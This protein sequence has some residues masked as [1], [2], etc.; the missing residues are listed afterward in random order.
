M[1]SES[2]GTSNDLPRHLAGWLPSRRTNVAPTAPITADWRGGPRRC[3][4]CDA[5]GSPQLVALNGTTPDFSLSAGSTATATVSPG[6]TATYTISVAPSGGFNQSVMFTCTGAPALTTCAVSPNP[7]SQNGTSA[8]MATVTVTTTAPSHGFAPPFE[9]DARWKVN[10]GPRLF[11]LGVLGMLIIASLLVWHRNRRTRWAPL[12]T[13]TVLLCMGITI[14][15]CGG[16]SSPSSTG[17]P[18]TQAGTYTITVSGS[19]ALSSSTSTHT[20]TL[21]LVVQ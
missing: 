8:A 20:A 11:M 13:L 2:L 18:G 21:T 6:Q 16:G 9:F 19:P 17:S 7:L 3:R 1:E 10:H 5:T 12:V 15:S 4:I 14:T